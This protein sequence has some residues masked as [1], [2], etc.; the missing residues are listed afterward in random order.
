MPM[1]CE[2]CRLKRATYGLPAEG[3]RRWCAGCA[4]AEGRRAVRLDKQNKMCEGCG[5]KRPS[6]GLPA[7][8]KARWCVG[9]AAAE[10][11]GA[12]RLQQQ[13]M[14]EGCGLKQ[15]SFGLPDADWTRRW[16]AGCS[17]PHRG[18]VNL[19]I[20]LRSAQLA[21]AR[22]PK[23]KTSK[24]TSKRPTDTGVKED[25]SPPLQSWTEKRLGDAIDTLRGSSTHGHC[26]LLH[27]LCEP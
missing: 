11:R 10:G 2:D 18:A 15:A 12:V 4:A 27:P 20:H 22:P 7:E 16:C 23:K 6:Y 26:K 21:A 25:P 9:C 5:S 8:R 17:Q 13:Q 24:K 14:C 1:M 3:R 19:S